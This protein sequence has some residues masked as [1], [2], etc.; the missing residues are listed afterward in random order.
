MYK[1]YIEDIYD[2]NAHLFVNNSSITTDATLTFILPY[3]ATLDNIMEFKHGRQLFD[4]YLDENRDYKLDKIKRTVYVN[5]ITNKYKYEKLISL[6][7]TNYNPLDEYDVIKQ[8]GVDKTTSNYGI[9][10]TTN[11]FGQDKKTSN[12]G[13]D[14]TTLDVGATTTTNTTAPRTDTSTDYSTA[15]DSAVEKVTAKT[16]NTTAQT[17][18]TI[19]V[20]A[21]TDETTRDARTDTSTRDAR[22][23]TST[24]DAKVDTSTRD[25][26]TDSESGRRTNAMDLI[27]KARGVASHNTLNVIINDTLNM[28]TYA[29]YL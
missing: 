15:F 19:G 7:E 18:D 13:E 6:D 24:K 27:A 14:K 16:T 17:V 3:L 5:L 20:S 4:R 21:H 11:V 9:D 23:D 1:M 10:K 22:T 2:D 25:A 8:Y 12:Y 28:L 29:M 26:R